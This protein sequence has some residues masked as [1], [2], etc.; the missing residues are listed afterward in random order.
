M[1][2]LAR[3]RLDNIRRRRRSGPRK[4]G[5][6]GGTPKDRFAEPF[7]LKKPITKEKD[8]VKVRI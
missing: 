4:L 3:A 2:R 7:A 1:S 6:L 5:D 8:L